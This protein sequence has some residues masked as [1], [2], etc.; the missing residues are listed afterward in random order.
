MKNKLVSLKDF[1]IL[2]V[3]NWGLDMRQQNVS[4]HEKINQLEAENQRLATLLSKRERYEVGDK[5]TPT[6]EKRTKTEDADDNMGN[7]TTVTGYFPNRGF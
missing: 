2:A 1:S 6:G 3:I 4:Q 5:E 7:P